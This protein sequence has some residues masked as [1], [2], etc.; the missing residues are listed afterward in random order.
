MPAP[1]APKRRLLPIVPA[2]FA[3]PIDQG[4]LSKKGNVMDLHSAPLLFGSFLASFLRVSPFFRQNVGKMRSLSDPQPKHGKQDQNKPHSEVS[5]V[6]KK[7]AKSLA[8][9]IHRAPE[10]PELDCGAQCNEVVCL[11]DFQ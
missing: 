4:E 10:Q 8:S 2:C 9:M 7:H 3:L 11:V 6:F 1:P 5:G